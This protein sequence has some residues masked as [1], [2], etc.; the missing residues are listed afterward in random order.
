[1]STVQEINKEKFLKQLFQMGHFWNPDNPNTL[2][3]KQ[4]DLSSLDLSHSLA[5]EAISSWQGF[6]QNFQ[7]I[8]FI[9]H[10][11]GIIAGEIGDVGPITSTM[12]NLPRCPMPDFP[13]PL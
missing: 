11:K 1:M 3:V 13:P 6:D 10:L 8:P 9:L 4:E 2:N 7:V 12:L 5:K